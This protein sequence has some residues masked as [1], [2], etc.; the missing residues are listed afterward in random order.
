MS[1]AL[2]Q[3]VAL[4]FAGAIVFDWAGSPLP[5]LLGPLICV[6]AAR[7]LGGE[8]VCP[9][10]A[11]AMG[12]W[13][14]GV[15]LGLYF[16]PQVF[17]Q[18]GALWWAILINLAWAWLISLT[19]AIVLCRA[20]GLDPVSAFFAGAIG[21]ASEM[22]IQSDRQGARVELVAA[23]HSVRVLIVVVSLPFVYQVLG[24][25][26]LDARTISIAIVDNQGLIVLAAL[27]VAMGWV[28]SRFNAPNAWMLGPMLMTVV[29]TGSGL[30]L[31]GLP[32]WLIK[33]GQVFIGMAL[34]SRFRRESM[35]Q[36]R[37]LTSLVVASTFALI[38]TAA[39]FAWMLSVLSGV[40]VATMVL[41]TSPGGI[42]EM[43]LTAK[44]L[45]LGVPVVTV[46][47]VTR[48]AFMLMTVGPVYRM[49]AVRYQWKL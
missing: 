31:S 24:L 13:V 19:F 37:S 25:Q 10:P 28:F 42:A 46:F 18:M 30:T 22:T 49:L 12:Q 8:M 38:L 7:M 43:S 23:I 9:T 17:S 35:S 21:G 1:L 45:Q 5:W 26:G 15:A 36:L 14:I 29:L 20:G 44:L 6:A 34:G 40:P 39:G 11:R 48:L 32:E 47:H 4:A 41:A 3:T 16:T 2:F 27:T 33:L